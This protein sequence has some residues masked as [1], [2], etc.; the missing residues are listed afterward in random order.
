MFG[1]LF[2][3]ET[4]DDGLK[5]EMGDEGDEGEMGEE[6]MPVRNTC[7]IHYIYITYI[8][9]IPPSF[10]LSLPSSHSLTLPPSLPSSLPPSL[11]LSLPPSLP[12]RDLMVQMV[13]L[14]MM[15]EMALMEVTGSLETK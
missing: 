13:H 1:N 3:G 8:L 11:P 12:L 6:G 9:S 15:V 5:G 14:V 10:S 4:G 2:Q 7:S